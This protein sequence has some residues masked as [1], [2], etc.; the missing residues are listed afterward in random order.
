MISYQSISPGSSQG[1][2]LLGI[3]VFCLLFGSIIGKMGDRGKDLQNF[4]DNLSKAFLEIIRIVIWM[5]PVGVFSLLC[6]TIIQLEQPSKVFQSLSL[7]VTTCFV[8]FLL[9]G[10]LVLPLLQ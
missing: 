7:Y 4:F 8:G 5:S 6:G 1:T 2:N 9:Q 3:L 10:V